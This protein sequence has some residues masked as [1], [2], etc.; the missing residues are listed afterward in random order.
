MSWNWFDTVL[1]EAGWQLSGSVFSE[2]TQTI[3]ASASLSHSGNLGS[4]GPKV[5]VKEFHVYY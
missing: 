1:D 4:Y 2:L 3:S 5:K